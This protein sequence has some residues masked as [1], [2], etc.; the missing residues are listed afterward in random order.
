MLYNLNVYIRGD[1][2][3]SI[4]FSRISR[5]WGLKRKI[6]LEKK[7]NARAFIVRSGSIFYVLKRRVASL[8]S[9][10]C[11]TEL[12]K[13]LVQSGLPVSAPIPSGSGEFEVKIGKYVYSLFPYIE[14]EKADSNISNA[15]PEMAEELGIFTGRLHRVLKEAEGSFFERTNLLKSLTSAIR[16]FNSTGS[17]F[18]RSDM[19]MIEEFFTDFYKLYYKLPVQIIHGDYHPGNI[20]VHEGKVSGIIDFDCAT[21]EVKAL[22]LAYLIHSVFAEFSRMGSPSLFL[23][24][25][26]HLLEGYCLENTLSF[27]ERESLGY[28][29]AA[30]SIIQIHYFS[31]NGLSD[32]ANFASTVFRWIYL[33]NHRI[34]EK[35]GLV[36]TR[37]EKAV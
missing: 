32:E 31:A 23:Y 29:L 14:G 25:L 6:V 34:K 35:S 8:P 22:D 21:R 18:S 3:S 9:R 33:N 26:P 1:N 30:I 27:N 16:Y 24:L 28:L 20:I 7:T 36:L 2:M 37:S 15:T 4:P 12:L 19:E 10:S 5:F 13:Y 11:Q 17:F